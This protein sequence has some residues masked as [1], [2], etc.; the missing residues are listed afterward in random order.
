MEKQNEHRCELT[1][2]FWEMGRNVHVTE[3]MVDNEWV[4]MT[5]GK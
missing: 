2:T 1:L 4:E 5:L 3:P